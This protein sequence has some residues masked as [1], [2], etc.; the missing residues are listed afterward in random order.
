MSGSA[1]A[2]FL[3]TDIDA[4]LAP[5]SDGALE[6]AV[7]KHVR[8]V[9]ARVPA[10]RAF[11][12]R[13]GIDAETIRTLAD[14]R[15]LP[16]TSK[17]NYYK[18]NSLPELSWDGALS[19]WHAVALSSGSTGEPAAWPRSLEHE[20]GVAVRFEQVLHDSFRGR[21]RST[22]AVIC[23]ALGSWVG[24]I[25]TAACMRHLAAKGYPLSV[26]TPGNQAAEIVR[27]L[28]LLAPHYEQIVLFGYPPFLKDLIDTA[29]A[30]GFS[31]PSGRVR[32]V[33]AGEVF[34][35]DWRSL[36][37][38]RLGSES[39][40]RD[41][42]SLYGT[43]D[44]GVLACE[45]PLSISIRRFLAQHRDLG[46]ELFGDARLPTLCQYD[47][48]QRFFEVEDGSG[49][50]LFTAPGAIPLVRYRILDRGGIR[51]FH[52]MLELC[53]AHEWEPSGVE[54]VREMPFVW[55][56]GRD[57]FAVSMDGANIY[58][59]QIAGALERPPISDAVTG[60]FV[61]SIGQ[62]EHLDPFLQCTV[63]LLPGVAESA[64][65]AA[66]IAADVRRLLEEANSEFSHYVPAA[67][68]TPRVLLRPYRDAEYFPAGIKHR[69]TRA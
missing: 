45:T 8:E 29:P 2:S 14:V 47:P 18:A 39:P 38:R 12:A 27:A 10:Y 3:E 33:T 65:L 59:E 46:R 68:R 19:G 49:N 43:A 22:L 9:G 32:I 36:V 30:L 64:A 63:E 61:L 28:R 1:L 57:H 31:W 69:Y 58:P 66:S 50:L 20:L 16:P 34:S 26:I 48:V 13:A 37:G 7:V 54:P 15:R 23:F 53:R 62:D 51:S 4:L 6:R 55:V 17:D 67:R 21:E 44:A 42:A 52:A 56:F 41:S 40:E 35:E 24:G 11:L 25:Y 60:K 5:A